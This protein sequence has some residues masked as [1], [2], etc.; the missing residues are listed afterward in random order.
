LLKE[1]TPEELPD[2]NYEDLQESEEDEQNFA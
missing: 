2:D 1:E